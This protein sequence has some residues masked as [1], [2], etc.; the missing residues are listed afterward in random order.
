M[1]KYFI[2]FQEMVSLR[3]LTDHYHCCILPIS[4]LICSTFPTTA[5]LHR[6]MHHGS[7]CDF[8]FGSRTQEIF[9][10]VRINA[11]ISQLR[12]FTLMSSMF[13]WDPLSLFQ[14]I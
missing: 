13:S 14:K 6:K 11:C 12:F 9:L 4:P 1:D 5:P 3:G 8:I 7:R 10:T 2:F